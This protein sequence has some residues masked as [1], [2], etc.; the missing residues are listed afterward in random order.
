MASDYIVLALLCMSCTI[1]V[2]NLKLYYV[3]WRAKFLDVL[4][5]AL[6]LYNKLA[7]LK[8][9]EDT[10]LLLLTS[11]LTSVALCL[12][13]DRKPQPTSPVGYE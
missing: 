12:Y 5:Y 2:A 4:K 8:K 1:S 3:L 7:N 9:E 10:T 13:K 6:C 11:L